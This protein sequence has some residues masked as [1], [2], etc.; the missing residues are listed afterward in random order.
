MTNAS[1]RADDYNQ[2]LLAD[3]RDVAAQIRRT[4]AF[5]AGRILLFGSGSRG[6]AR[7]SS[8]L[9]IMVIAPSERSFKER[10][11]AL[12]SMVDPPRGADLLWY[13][14]EEVEAMSKAGNSFIRHA[15]ATATEIPGE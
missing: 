11:R 2:A 4:I 9:D 15:L 1:P 7:Q 5:A 6:D 13:T 10:Q 14:P 3:A 8:D 12:Y